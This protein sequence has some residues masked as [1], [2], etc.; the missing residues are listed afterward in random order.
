M[1]VIPGA[2]IART[3]SVNAFM[4]SR[5]D[6]RGL[7]VGHIKEATPNFGGGKTAGREA[8]D[9]AEVVRATFEGAPEVRIG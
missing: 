6:F 4:E 8:R 7:G 5:K 1:I 9:D 2:G 3:C